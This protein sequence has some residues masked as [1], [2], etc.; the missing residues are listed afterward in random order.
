MKIK[1]LWDEVYAEYERQL[2]KL[3]TGEHKI[4]ICLDDVYVSCD[5]YIDS[6]IYRHQTQLQPA[7]YKVTIETSNIEVESEVLTTE[8]QIEIIKLCD[9]HFDDTYYC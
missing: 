4:E 7:E 8:E 2:E 1:K 5:V 6:E 3:S 9:K